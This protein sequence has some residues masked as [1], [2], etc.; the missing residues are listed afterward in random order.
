MKI[1]VASDDGKEDS[2]VSPIMGRAP[3]FIIFEDGKMAK[4]IGNPFR[5]GG[6]GAGLGVVQMLH[7][8]GVEMIIG[9][10]FGPKVIDSMEEKGI[11]YKV[12]EGSSAKEAAAKA[13]GQD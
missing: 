13:E 12:I 5:V 4:T 3:H 10:K 8:E 9:G 6:G 1:A 2:P 7:N 11:K